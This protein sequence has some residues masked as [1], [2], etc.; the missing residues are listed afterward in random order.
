MITFRINSF[1]Q[2]LLLLEDAMLAQEIMIP[3]YFTKSS[4]EVEKIVGDIL[5]SDITDDNRRSAA[6]TILT[7]VAANGYQI[8]L[9]AKAPSPKPDIKVATIHGYLSGTSYEGKTPTIVIVAHY[10][11]FGIAPVKLRWYHV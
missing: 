6:E 2:H 4:P 5:Q 1:F 10:D 8:V 11:T 9:S 7:S 3:V